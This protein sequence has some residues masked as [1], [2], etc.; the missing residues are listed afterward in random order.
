MSPAPRIRHQNIV[1]NFHINLKMHPENPCYTGIAPTD[2]VLDEY[3]VVQPDVFIV[4]DGEKITENNVQGAPDLIVEVVSPGMEVKDRRER[5]G[6]YEKSGVFE[7][8]RRFFACYTTYLLMF[9]NLQQLFFLVPLGMLKNNAAKFIQYL[10]HG[11]TG[12]K[13]RQFHDRIAVDGQIRNM[14]GRGG[15]ELCL[16]PFLQLGKQTLV[17]LVFSMGQDIGFSKDQKVPDMVGSN[18]SN[19]SPDRCIAPLGVVAD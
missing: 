16:N 7:F 15:R 1:S 13:S 11:W 18:P 6:L 4:C 12:G 2:V 5:K 17:P 10:P 14:G 9:N 3:S 8:Q 19:Q